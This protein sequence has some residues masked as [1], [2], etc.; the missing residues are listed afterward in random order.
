M[1][2][3]IT[4]PTQSAL[5][6]F[7]SSRFELALR[8]AD[9]L[10][11]SDLLPK[12]FQGRPE[13]C[14]IA[15]ELAERMNA[16]PFMVA[17]NVDIIH[18]KPSFSAKFL[19]GCF[20]NCGRFSPIQYKVETTGAPVTVQVEIERWTGGQGSRQKVTDK[21]S[22]TYTP[23]TCIAY[24]THRASG[25]IVSGPP[26]S[27]DMALQEGWVSKDGSKWLTEMREL[28]IR[29]RAA[30]FLVRTVAPEISLG[31]PTSEE[32]TDTGGAMG[33]EVRDVT[34]RN[35]FARADAEKTV[36]APEPAKEA[37]TSPQDQLRAHL[38]S[39]G[40]SVKE[41]LAAVQ[42]F[43]IGDGKTPFS[44]MD[45]ATIGKIIQSWSLVETAVEN[46]RHGKEGE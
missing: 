7:D 5:S 23:T 36:E 18:G 39:S 24:A 3:E 11:K 31:L 10:S 32:I 46:A 40:F 25:E 4:I 35:P 22:W 44:K 12:A 17:Q 21:K 34:P 45:D 38:E 30:T 9:M 43:G 2:N 8:Q 20:N 26:V 13:N 41:T 1:T 29:Y 16:S 42:T 33:P 27:Y 37:A 15:L 28:M 14:L 19:I 6:I